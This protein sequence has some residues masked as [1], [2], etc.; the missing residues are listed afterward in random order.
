[1]T[2]SLGN[3]LCYVRGNPRTHCT[4]LHVPIIYVGLGDLSNSGGLFEVRL[5][6]PRLY[7]AF[8]RASERKA[9][10]PN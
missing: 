7:E 1:M 4:A 2:L 3:F 10:W 8:R 5:F 9:G 6:S